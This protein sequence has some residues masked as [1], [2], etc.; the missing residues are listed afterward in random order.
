MPLEN[1]LWNDGL[2]YHSDAPWVIDP[3][4]REGIHCVL[5]LSRVQEEFE[6]IAQEL[7]RAMSWA[8]E[9]HNTLVNSLAYMGE[10]ISVL[11]VGDPEV[12]ADHI[13]KQKLTGVTQRDSVKVIR[14]EVNR[15]LLSHCELVKG[16]SEDVTWLWQH[17]QPAQN[18]AFLDTWN[19]FVDQIRKVRLG[20]SSNDTERTDDAL[21]DAVLDKLVDD[22]EDLDNA[23]D[24]SV[25]Q[26]NSTA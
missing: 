7:V 26:T 6:L 16:W 19:K 8:I 24:G 22:G 15:Q 4:V 20:G 17:C 12:A 1:A 2:F 14:N 11:K 25:F 21:E 3:N 23:D 10:R 9:F 5:V 18:A 13:D